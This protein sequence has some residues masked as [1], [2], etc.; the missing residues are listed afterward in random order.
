[1]WYNECMK[2]STSYSLSPEGLNLIARLA[3]LL[4]VSQAA[5]IEMGVRELAKLHK[6]K[7]K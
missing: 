3:E 2:R 5:V 6:V 4:G 1:M 7:V